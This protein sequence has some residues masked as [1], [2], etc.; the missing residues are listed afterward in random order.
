[1]QSKDY[2]RGPYDLLHLGVIKLNLKD[3]KGAIDSFSKQIAYND[4]QAENYYYLAK[5]NAAQNQ[6]SLAK[7]AL[8]KAL[9]YYGMGKHL[10]DPYTHHADRV[11]LSEIEAF[12]EKVS[13]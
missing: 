8:E 6:P 7:E 2:V 11:F 3:Y 13:Q 10:R 4:Y 9:S 5:A 12:L 1:M